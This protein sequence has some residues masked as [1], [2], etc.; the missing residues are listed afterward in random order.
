MTMVFFTSSLYQYVVLGFAALALRLIAGA[1]QR[2]Y[3]SPISKFPGP[4]LA[5]LTFW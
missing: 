1:V 4:K 2:L 5:A 3:F